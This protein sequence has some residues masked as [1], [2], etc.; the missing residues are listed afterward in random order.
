MGGDLGR[1]RD[2]GE[3]RAQRALEA[4]DGGGGAGGEWGLSHTEP[5][6]AL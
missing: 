3:A 5:T 1:H 6:H 2:P 4:R